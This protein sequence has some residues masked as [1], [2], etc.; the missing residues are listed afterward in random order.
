M[1]LKI[2]K[3]C[4]N[5]KVIAPK[6]GDG[7]LDI[8]QYIIC[9]QVIPSPYIQ[10]IKRVVY[11]GKILWPGIE[12]SDLIIASYDNTIGTYNESKSGYKTNIINRN[13]LIKKVIYNGNVIWPLDDNKYLNIE[14][15]YI[16]ISE[17][18]NWEDTNQIYTNTTFTII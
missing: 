2:K 5:G 15:E 4:Y 17:F 12:S 16:S 9:G 1:A 18:N 8:I 6:D 3:I 10:N 14:K 11:N 13:P 7:V